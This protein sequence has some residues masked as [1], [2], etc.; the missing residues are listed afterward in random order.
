MAKKTVSVNTRIGQG[1]LIDATVRQFNIKIDQPPP[2][3]ND[4]G[5]NPVEFMLL[6]LGGCVCT[7]GRILATQKRIELRSIDC[8]VEGVM[9][10]DVI[11]GKNTTDRAGFQHITVYVKLDADMT[12]SE[13]EQFL[14]EIEARCPV[15]DNIV[16]PSTVEVKIEA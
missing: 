3:G 8:R 9:D 10:S 7:V 12:T 13:K 15:S 14:H 4:E 11:M 6:A 5:P 16:N 1:F 2:G